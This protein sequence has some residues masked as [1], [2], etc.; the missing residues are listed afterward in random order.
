MRIEGRGSTR[1]MRRGEVEARLMEW[2]VKVRMRGD[3]ARDESAM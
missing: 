3:E 2:V 1:W